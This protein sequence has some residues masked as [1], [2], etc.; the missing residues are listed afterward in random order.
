MRPLITAF[1]VAITV[2]GC[3]GSEGDSEP[4]DA[5]ADILSEVGDMGI[6][7]GIPDVGIPDV[8]VDPDVQP[9]D[10]HVGPTS[11]PAIVGGQ[12]FLNTFEGGFGLKLEGTDLENDVMGIGLELLD[13][14]GQ[15]FQLSENGGPIDVRFSLLRQGLGNWIGFFS[16]DFSID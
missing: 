14:D 3:G 11:I 6:D 9:P 5:T 2:W 15:A 1:C 10:M 4:A 7:R 8:G 16:S 13:A 12:A